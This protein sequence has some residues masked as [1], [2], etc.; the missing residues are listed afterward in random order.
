MSWPDRV[1]VYHKLRFAPNTATDSFM[2]DVLILSERHQRA[3][4]RCVEDIVVYDYRWGKKTSL[5]PFMLEQFSKTWEAQEE[6]KRVNGSKALEIVERVRL[7][8]KERSETAGLMPKSKK[9]PNQHNT[10]HENGVVAP[11]KRITKQKSNG[12]LSG[13]SDGPADSL[14]SPSTLVSAAAPVNHAA[15][16]LASGPA[17]DSK[18]DRNRTGSA[19]RS[20]GDTSGDLSEDIESMGNGTAHANG[21][22]E[23]NHR[24]IDVNAAKVAPV[25][26]NTIFNLA[27]TILRSCPLGDT[28]AILI[29]LLSLPPTLLSVTNALFAVLTF[30]PPAGSFSSFP[31]TLNDVFQG[32]GGTPSLPTILVTDALGIVIWLVA[33]SPLQMLVLELAQAVVATT[34]GGGNSSSNSGSDSTLFCM[35][36][37]FCTHVAQ[38]RWIP[39]RIFGYEWSVRLAS[40]PY[41]EETFS[42]RPVDDGYQQRSAGGWFRILIALHI[43][44]QGLVHVARRWYTKREYSQT[45]NLSK[46]VD[47]EAGANTQAN[48]DA[49]LA[50]VNT[51]AESVSLSK[52]SLPTSREARDR[53]SNTRRRRKQGT[54]VRS[55]QPLWAAF[56]ATKVTVLRE[57]EQSHAQSEAH[58][59]NATDARNLGSAPFPTEEGRIWITTVQPNNILFDASHFSYPQSNEKCGS[60]SSPTVSGGIDRSKPFFVR[61]NGADWTS[62]K[63]ENL[64]LDKSKDASPDQRWT[65]KIHGLSPSSSYVCSFVRSEDGVVVHSAIVSTPSS[66]AVEQELP[67]LASPAQPAVR[68]SSPTTPSTTL[69]KSIAACEISLNESQARQKRNKKEH[70]LAAAALKKDID[71]NNAS[72][73]KQN[74]SEKGYTSRILQLSQH[75]KQADEA[76]LSITNEIE[77]IGNIPEE[78]TQKWEAKKAV[79]DLIRKQLDTAKQDHLHYKSAAQHEMQA[80]DAEASSTQQKR[81]RLLARRTK[82]SDQCERLQSANSQDLDEKERKEVE[83]AAVLAGRRQ[84]EERWNEQM[85][86]LSRAIQ[87]TQYHTQQLLQQAD[88][89]AN[90]FQTPQ[91]IALAAENHAGLAEADGLGTAAQGTPSSGFG[92]RL[93]AFNAP[94]NVGLYN[95]IGSFRQ[96]S[97]P[98]SSSLRTGSTPHADFLDQ[99][100]APPM[101]SSQAM[102]LIRGRQQSGSSGSGSNGSQRDPASPVSAL[103][104][105]KSPVVK[106]GSPI[107]N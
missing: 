93:P 19:I 107:W 80:V 6:A 98:R 77:S 4:A 50:S 59:S 92:L 88:L 83:H 32:S 36:I 15:V 85:T 71:K 60:T 9:A 95:G 22:L 106:K 13:H 16:H 79:W 74:E 12:H 57:M 42:G 11:G 21:S 47:P 10:R 89:L 20:P 105:R 68:P 30:M 64:A 26:D 82:L 43:L 96:D 35:L 70:K 25:Q 27:L 63:I 55:Q 37:V 44:I 61:I 34:L 2:L 99:D 94:D 78:D 103:G 31:T 72:I 28:I 87:E 5:P 46:K 84:A 65:G 49:G 73:A 66:P 18:Y 58:G 48:T 24:K 67:G 39:K 45:I 52:L 100:P 76:L 7:L 53:I 14:N 41:I 8:E 62:T 69:K 3:A 40:I 104:N 1:S 102:K 33:W 56:A 29:F 38:H 91:A 75:L 101:P 81:E 97:R 90:A 86:N 51:P 54:Y 23:H 17:S